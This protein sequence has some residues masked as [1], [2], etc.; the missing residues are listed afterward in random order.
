MSK[1]ITLASMKELVSNNKLGKVDFTY[2]NTIITINP[3]LSFAEKSTFIDRV[4]NS[5][6]TSDGEFLPEY[7]DLITFITLIQMCSNMPTP[8]KDDKLDLQ[9]GYEWMVATDL[10]TKIRSSYQTENTNIEKSLCNWFSDLED[11]IANKIEFKKQEI[12][13]N[14]KTPLDELFVSIN[15]IVSNF[16]GSLDDVKNLIPVISKLAQN[17][18]IDEKAIIETIIHE[19]YNNKNDEVSTLE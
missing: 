12:L 3:N 8:K 14:K 18:D 6:F 9:L 17:K 5:C 13:V 2:G 11:C 15:N 4:V 19:K 10:L 7:V 16:E 1:T